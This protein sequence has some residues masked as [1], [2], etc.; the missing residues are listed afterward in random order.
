MVLFLHLSLTKSEYFFLPALLNFLAL[1]KSLSSRHL[2]CFSN[3]LKYLGTICSKKPSLVQGTRK[4][5]EKMQDQEILSIAHLRSSF[6]DDV[7][8]YLTKWKPTSKFQLHNPLQRNL[9]FSLRATLY[10]T[11]PSHIPR[12]RTKL[13][14]C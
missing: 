9:I 7:K 8:S 11:I 2:D 13:I 5:D 3:S 14:K 10:Q 12:F 6:A 4:K 1:H